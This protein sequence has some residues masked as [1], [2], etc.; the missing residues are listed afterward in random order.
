MFKTSG[1][2]DIRKMFVQNDEL[3]K[4]EEES[5]SEIDASETPSKVQNSHIAKRTFSPKFAEIGKEVNSSFSFR[6]QE[7]LLGLGID[8]SWFIRQ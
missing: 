4:I 3:S 2:R 1:Q 5:H 8:V 7:C 6:K